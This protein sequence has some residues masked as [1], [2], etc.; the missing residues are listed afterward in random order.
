M[1]WTWRGAT[2]LTRGVIKR[3]EVKFDMAKR[4]EYSCKIDCPKCKRTGIAEYEENANP[5]YG[6]GFEQRV[7]SVSVGF[8][9]KQNNLHQKIY[10]I[11][12]N[13]LIN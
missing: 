10:C 6:N 3:I 9:I 2:P 5:V 13:E 8:E 12:C 4:E 7:C 11:N 1:Q